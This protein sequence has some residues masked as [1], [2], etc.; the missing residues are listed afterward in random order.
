MIMNCMTIAM[1]IIIYYYMNI[2]LLLSVNYVT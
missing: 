2:I 1:Q